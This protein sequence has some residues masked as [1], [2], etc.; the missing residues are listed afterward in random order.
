MKYVFN[1]RHYSRHWSGYFAK[2][3]K[4]PSLTEYS[5]Q[6]KYVIKS[7]TYKSAIFMS[8]ISSQNKDNFRVL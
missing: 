3:N 8:C 6:G 4:I 5:Y 7:K 2:E 1:C